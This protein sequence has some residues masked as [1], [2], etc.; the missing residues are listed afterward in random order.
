MLITLAMQVRTNPPHV[1]HVGP[2]S[3]LTRAPRNTTCKWLSPVTPLA[4]SLFVFT[5]FTLRRTLYP[6]SP[7]I[8]MSS[9]GLLGSLYEL[10]REN[11]VVAS[12]GGVAILLILLYSLLVKRGSD[13]IPWLPETI[14]F[15]SNT[16]QVSTDT[17]AFWA[18]AS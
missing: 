17:K 5:V 12:V 14:P 4:S 2:P 15:L 1:P 9:Q 16:L 6:A 7:G 3:D 11:A 13:G 10:A 18:R 8:I